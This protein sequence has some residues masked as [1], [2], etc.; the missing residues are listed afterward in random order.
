MKLPR[1]RQVTARLSDDFWETY[2]TRIVFF[3][4]KCLIRTEK[5]H[6]IEDSQGSDN[7][8]CLRTYL[9]EFDESKV[10]RNMNSL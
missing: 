2:S 3:W 6:R 8:S 5:M 4:L 9:G 7:F 1:S 10:G